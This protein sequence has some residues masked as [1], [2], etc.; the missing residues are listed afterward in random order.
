MAVV[1]RNPQNK[2]NKDELVYCMVR[3]RSLLTGVRDEE[4]DKRVRPEITKSRREAFDGVMLDI[5]GAPAKQF[6]ERMI[7]ARGIQDNLRHLNSIGYEHIVQLTH[8]DAL[9][10]AIWIMVD[11]RESSDELRRQYKKL[12]KMKKECNRKIATYKSRLK[13]PTLPESERLRYTKKN[14]KLEDDLDAIRKKR[15]KISDNVNYT[16]D[17]YKAAM[18]TLHEMTGIHAVKSKNAYKKR[19]AGLKHFIDMDRTYYVDGGYDGGIDDT[20]SSFDGLMGVDSDGNYIVPE[21]N[22]DES[23]R[24]RFVSNISENDEDDEY[25]TSDVDIS[26]LNARMS[27]IE[28]ALT[29]IAASLQGRASMKEPE[30]PMYDLSPSNEIVEDADGNYVLRNISKDD[31]SSV[32][33]NVP[34]AKTE[35]P[36]ESSE[37]AESDLSND[38]GELKKMVSVLAKKTMDNDQILTKL[39]DIVTEDSS[40]EDDDSM[41]DIIPDEDD[42]QAEE[43]KKKESSS[44]TASADKKK[45]SVEASTASISSKPDEKNDQSPVHMPIGETEFQKQQR[46]QE[47]ASKEALSR[48]QEAESLELNVEAS[49]HSITADPMKMHT[50]EIDALAKEVSEK[51]AKLHEFKIPNSTEANSLRREIISKNKELMRMRN[52]AASLV[53]LTR[54]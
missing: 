48:A 11:M 42:V 7:V 44:S 33:P 40:D 25:D 16:H 49:I 35:K 45:E 46:E 34:K 41:E 27:K 39:I 5:F 31:G 15:K 43:N 10:Q 9:Y 19:W 52:E 13:D 29:T 28:S 18:K 20:D 51:T 53:E 1:R 36:K 4:A 54:G 21:Y 12:G 3:L 8:V 38:I 24:A 6:A 17:V 2:H 23:R 50:P 37:T 47:E 14:R 26:D 30:D 32:T 22:P